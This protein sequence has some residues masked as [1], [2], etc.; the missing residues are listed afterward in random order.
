MK[1]VRHRIIPLILSLII[2]IL[3]PLRICASVSANPHIERVQQIHDG[4][5][6][7]CLRQSGCA[8]VEEWIG[9]YSDDTV[10]YGDEWYMLYLSQSGSYDFSEYEPHLSAY[11]RTKRIGAASSKQ[12][13]ALCLAAIGSDD[14][15][16]STVLDSTVGKQGLM[17][18]VFGL[19]LLNNGYHS[20]E[21]T[22]EQAISEIL[23]LQL[24]DGGW[25][26]SGD[27]SNAD[28]TAMAIQALA[29]HA[30]KSDAVKQAIDDAVSCL[31]VL[32]LP[33]GDYVSY[34]AANAESAAQVL[35]ALSSIGI[36]AM[37]DA[38]FIK[39]GNTLLDVIEK[40]RLPDGSFCHTENGTTS[41]MATVQVFGALISYLRFV[42][43]NNAL[44]IL[45]GAIPANVQP[46]DLFFMQS[47]NHDRSVPSM[48]AVPVFITCGIGLIGCIFVLRQYRKRPKA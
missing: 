20:A 34:G 44:Y 23:A 35:I 41:E 6:S 5:L 26:I 28:A 31:S 19:H 48:Q 42:N 22:T 47:E 10:G 39:S 37:Q 8:S 7:Y 1:Q 25:A 45:D 46:S 21:Y 43:G 38:R 36:D 12:K 32:A 33:E 18:L 27:S 15:Y 40:Y 16:I 9:S 17:S 2:G 24:D 11:V 14:A 29:P 13:L 3:S 30:E 4:I